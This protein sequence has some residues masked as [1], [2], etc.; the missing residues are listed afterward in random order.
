MMDFAEFEEFP[1]DKKI[2]G[3]PV[4]LIIGKRGCGKTTLISDILDRLKLMDSNL[5]SNCHVVCPT[6]KFQKYYSNKY[7]TVKTA[8]ELTD[9]LMKELLSPSSGIIILDDCLTTGSL[10]SQVDPSFNG[11]DPTSQRISS[12]HNESICELIKNGRNYQKILIISIQYPINIRPEI[13]INFDYIFLFKEDS[14]CNQK[15]LWDKYASIFPTFHVF[16]KAFSTCTRDY[17][18]MVID[19][20]Y[21]ADTIY[22]KVFRYK[23]KHQFFLE[24]IS[25]DAA[26]S[27]SPVISLRKDQFSSPLPIATETP[28]GTERI[29]HTECIDHQDNLQTESYSISDII[30]DS[31]D[32]IDSSH[33]CLDY[34]SSD[35]KDNN[36]GDNNNIESTA[37]LS[38]MFFTENILPNQNKNSMRD[39]S[40]KRTFDKMMITYND[41]NY[42]FM[43]RMNNCQDMNMLVT[44]NDQMIKLKKLELKKLKLTTRN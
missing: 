18:T 38:D 4:I 26:G 40:Q 5:V 37:E 39:L 24:P 35:K 9:D 19:Q 17:S 12:I 23:A 2:M 30:S 1:M 20:S 33:D 6:D 34:F 25:S 21:A 43:V 3:Y 32:V 11:Q 15:N 36:N 29:V 42:H 10:I 41:E 31:H 28:T 16:I 14:I 44:L 27:A 8:H 7:P 22:E 13:R